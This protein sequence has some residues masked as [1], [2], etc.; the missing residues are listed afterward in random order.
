MSELHFLWKEAAVFL[1]QLPL[2]S[3][4]SVATPMAE[5][6]GAGG[7]S[8]VRWLVHSGVE[9]SSESSSHLPSCWG[10]C[11]VCVCSGLLSSYLSLRM[12]VRAGENVVL[13]TSVWGTVSKPEILLGSLHL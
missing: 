5:E 7:G 11:D 6:L 12:H 3:P 13:R 1:P 9:E 10:V 8:Q 2:R 4:C